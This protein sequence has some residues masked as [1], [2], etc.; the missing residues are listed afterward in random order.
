MYYNICG[1]EARCKAYGRSTSPT[2]QIDTRDTNANGCAR[3]NSAFKAIGYTLIRHNSRSEDSD[4]RV[5]LIIPG[6]TP[7]QGG[8]SDVIAALLNESLPLG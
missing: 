7:H 4:G 1:N 6:Y 8:E 2:K 3:G 5:E